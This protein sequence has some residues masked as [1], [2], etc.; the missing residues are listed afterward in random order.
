MMGR[1]SYQKTPAYSSNLD[2]EIVEE[3]LA[4]TQTETFAERKINTLSGGEQQRVFLAAAVAQ[5]AKILLLDEPTTFLDPYQVRNIAQ[6]IKRII[7]KYNTTILSVSHEMNYSISLHNNVLAL[8]DTKVYFSG[9][10]EDFMSKD[11]SIAEKIFGVPFEKAKL[12]SGETAIFPQL[13]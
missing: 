6:A 12:P 13:R 10:F 8:K 7:Q 4:L 1:Y 11:L 2:R 9:T 5:Q 3:S